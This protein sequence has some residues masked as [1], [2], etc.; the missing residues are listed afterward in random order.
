MELGRY[1]LRRITRKGQSPPL[2]RCPLFMEFA[3]ATLKIALNGRNLI[4]CCRQSLDSAASPTLC[5][6]LAGLVYWKQA[7]FQ[8]FAVHPPPHAQLLPPTQFTNYT[9][10]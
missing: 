6:V 2:S 10:K 3:L 5:N 8:R 1:Q 9:L 7:L 4:F